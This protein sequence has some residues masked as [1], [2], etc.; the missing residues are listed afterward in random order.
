MNMSLVNPRQPLRG[1]TMI[2]V[3]VVFVILLALFLLAWTW[4]VDE[5]EAKKSIWY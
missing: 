1:K 5:E 4:S 3:I 2:E